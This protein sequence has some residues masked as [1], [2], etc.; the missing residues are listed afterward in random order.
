MSPELLLVIVQFCSGHN[1]TSNPTFIMPYK[2]ECITKVTECAH[3]KLKGMQ[4]IISSAHV[5]QCIKE[6]K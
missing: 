4:T 3:K 1:S 6:Y 5:Y 2:V